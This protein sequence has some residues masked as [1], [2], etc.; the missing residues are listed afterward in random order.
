[1]PRFKFRMDFLISLRR[2]REEAAAAKLAKRLAGIAEL[3]RLIAGLEDDLGNLAA[4]LSERGRRGDLNGPILVM[5]SSHQERLRQE[6]KKDNHLLRLSRN[7][8]VKERRALRKAMI[9]RKII[10]RAK[11]RRREAWI[12]EA[13][14]TE[15]SSLE[16]LAAISKER[17]RR[18]E[19][20][21]GDP[22]EQGETAGA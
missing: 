18:N 3:E 19:A 10:E 22:R 9:D 16:E 17:S 14:R 1:M 15:Q 11:E 21:D 12:E 7:E 2:R 4:E 6:L 8:E 13:A 5:Y 20:S